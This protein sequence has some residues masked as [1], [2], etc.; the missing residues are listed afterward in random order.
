MGIRY[1]AYAFDN[2]QRQQA[3]TDPRSIIAEDPLADAWGLPPG[4]VTGSSD[5]RQTSPEED[6]LYLDKAWVELQRITGPDAEGGAPRPAYARFEGEP[7]WTGGGPHHSWVRVILPEDLPAIAEDL[8][9]IT[10]DV[11][12][13]RLR[14]HERPGRDVESERRYV[15]DF[16]G[17]ARRFATRL[18]EDG[19]GM[20]YLI[21]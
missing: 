21:G 6:M 18:V 10:T 5:F 3:V 4:F 14:G 16:L 7:T 11:V 19:R 12:I 15:L 8:M 13:S 17:R 20:A 1:Y 9:T 2:D